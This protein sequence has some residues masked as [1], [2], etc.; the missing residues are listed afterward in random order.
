MLVTAA[1]MIAWIPDSSVVLPTILL[2]MAKGIV[3]GL[4]ADQIASQ[5]K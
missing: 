2:L 4:L 3:L 5:H 1:S